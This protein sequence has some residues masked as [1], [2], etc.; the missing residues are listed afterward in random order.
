MVTGNTF[1]ATL[2]VDQF[3]EILAEYAVSAPAQKNDRKHVYGL[4]GLARLLGCSVPTAQRLKSSGAIDG[5]F[6]Q[7]GRKLIFDANAVLEAAGKNKGGKY[8]GSRK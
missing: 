7:C 3:R 8:D 1:I 4:G 6:V 2:T 5:A